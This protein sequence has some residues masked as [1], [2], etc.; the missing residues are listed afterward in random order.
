MSYDGHN[1][2]KSFFCHSLAVEILRHNF[3]GGAPAA[4]LGAKWALHMTVYV[5]LV[6]RHGRVSVLTSYTSR[7]L[8]FGDV[9]RGLESSI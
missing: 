1:I 4:W 3:D 7:Y 6:L 9:A 2:C 5:D 8:D